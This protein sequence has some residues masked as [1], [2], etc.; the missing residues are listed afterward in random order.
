MA[1]AA[2]RA[3]GRAAGSSIMRRRSVALAWQVEGER[4][5][6][7]RKRRRG[8]PVGNPMARRHAWDGRHPKGRS[9]PR[10]RGVRAG[11]GCRWPLQGRRMVLRL[12]G[13]RRMLLRLHWSDNRGWL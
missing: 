12:Q 5:I 3:T 6:A 11:R 13:G 2:E 4:R 1:R 7:W 8:W 10:R 9:C